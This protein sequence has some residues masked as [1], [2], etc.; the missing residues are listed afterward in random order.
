MLLRYYDRAGVEATFEPTSG[1]FRLRPSTDL[2]RLLRQADGVFTVLA[3][4]V[5]VLVTSQEGATV[6]VGSRS[7]PL[8]DVVVDVN[9]GP[10]DRVLTI[11][12]LSGEVDRFPYVVTGWIDSDTTPGVELEDFDFGLFLCNVRYDPARQRRMRGLS[13]E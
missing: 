1:D 7:S 4:V 3:G 8:N 11:T 6:R 10:S 2:G 9:G 13:Q 5:L 12:W